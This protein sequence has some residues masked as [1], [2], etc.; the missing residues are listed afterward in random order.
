MHRDRLSN[1]SL[2]SLLFLAVSFAAGRSDAVSPARSVILPRPLPTDIITR[3]PPR[4]PDP[5]PPPTIAVTSLGQ[6]TEG[7]AL[8]FRITISRELGINLPIPYTLSGDTGALA[9]PETSGQ[10]TIVEGQRSVDIALPTRDDSAV[11]GQRTIVLTI[12]GSTTRAAAGQAWRASGILL[13]NDQNPPPP[14]PPPSLAVA[15]LGDVREGQP[16]RYRITLSRPLNANLAIGYTLS[17]DTAA[18][19]NPVSNGRT[20]IAEGQRFGDV[21]LPTRDDPAINGRRAVVLSL[22]A[23]TARSA[24]VQNWRA[25][26][27]IVDVVPPPPPPPVA[28]VFN[29]GAVEEGGTLRFPLG[30]DR[31]AQ[32]ELT[33]IYRVTDAASATGGDR[34]GQVTIPAGANGAVIS[35]VSRDDSAVNGSRGVAVRLLRID[36]ATIGPQAI[37]SGAITDN[38]RAAP[39]SAAPSDPPATTA[40]EQSAT[41]APSATITPSEPANTTP[42]PSATSPSTSPAD[43][44]QSGAFVDPDADITQ[45]PPTPAWWPLLLAI[46]ALAAIVGAAALAIRALLRVAVSAEPG[47]PGVVAGSLS[48]TAP[49]LT[50]SAKATTGTVASGPIENLAIVEKYDDPSP[51]A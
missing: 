34:R 46:A 20:V 42:A 12:G 48:L 3:V 8:R 50:I 40:A 44:G 37:G 26:G 25:S 32:R 49:S 21:T 23:A 2:I 24:T 30:L 19:A 29:A 5:P 33:A 11:N 45:Q 6:V 51:A 13:D 17:G 28:A 41:P 15:S 22:A 4:T 14:P 1:L 47:V 10:A 27:G 9:R 31:P 38:D 35:L 16:L 7:G 39:S 36:G 43:D 18:L